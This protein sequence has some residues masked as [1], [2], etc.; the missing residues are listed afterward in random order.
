MPDLNFLLK[1][2]DFYFTLSHSPKIA[3]A[4]LIVMEF[5]VLLQFFSKGIG[6]VKCI[7]NNLLFL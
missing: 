3:Q 7:L 2:F 1:V 4:T 6:G 5:E